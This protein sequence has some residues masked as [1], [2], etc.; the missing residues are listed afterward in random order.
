MNTKFID[1][2]KK[3]RCVCCEKDKPGVTATSTIDGEMCLY[4]IGE[5]HYDG[6]DRRTEP[7]TFKET[8]KIRMG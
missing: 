2:S 6:L 5:M 1:T 3:F 4:C 7:L 8:K